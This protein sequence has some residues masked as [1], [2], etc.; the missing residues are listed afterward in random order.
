[1]IVVRGESHECIFKIGIAPLDHAHDI[2]RVPRVHHLI[3]R[4]DI[5]SEFDAFEG[6][7]WKR[8]LLRGFLFQLGVLDLGAAEDKFEELIIRRHRRWYWMIQ[9][10][11]S[12]EIA[13]IHAT[14]DLSL[15]PS[16]SLS[17]DK[18]LGNW[19]NSSQRFLLFSREATTPNQR[20]P[21]FSSESFGSGAAE[22][23]DGFVLNIL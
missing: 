2:A 14:S 7:G 3:I 23:D 17:S 22:I 11:D 1:M 8:L 4:V 5:E 21:V 13:L 18:P 9:S 12:R 16:T 10:L 19:T 6:E 20:A 15:P